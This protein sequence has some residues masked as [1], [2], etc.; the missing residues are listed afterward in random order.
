VNGENKVV[1]RPVKLGIQTANRAEVIAGLHEG[2]LV[3][4]GSRS[5]VQA[6]MVVSPKQVEMA[7]VSE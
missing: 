6:G 2:D 7:K 1:E 5:Q 4:M 3:V